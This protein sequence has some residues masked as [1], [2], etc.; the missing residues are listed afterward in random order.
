MDLPP[1]AEVL[2]KTVSF[3]FDP[4]DS[5]WAENYQTCLDQA[6]GMVRPSECDRFC[7]DVVLT[8]STLQTAQR[9]GEALIDCSRP[10]RPTIT[11]QYYTSHCDPSPPPGG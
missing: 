1:C 4:N 11:V 7:A 3:P 2:P 9:L 5:R 8:S 10:D 6:G